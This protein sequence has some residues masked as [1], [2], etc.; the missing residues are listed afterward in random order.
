MNKQLQLIL[1]I[2][3]IAAIV[4]IVA[5]GQ[6]AKNKKTDIQTTKPVPQS[7][8]VKDLLQTGKNLS[9]TLT[10]P[11]GN[12][13][14]TAFVAPGKLRTDFKVKNQDQNYESHL[15]QTGG[16]S[17]FWSGSTGLKTMVNTNNSEES[18]KNADQ[19][20]KFSCSDW[21]V[22]NSKFT[23]PQDVTFTDPNSEDNQ[24]NIEPGSTPS[25]K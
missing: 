1:G 4:G 9:C 20:A 7:G 6:M 15:I 18:T 24:K 2:L 21:N 5:Y 10:Y 12:T 8:S 11:D 19:Q 13:T 22:D 23:L 3:L 14:G 16:F 17:Y 25:A